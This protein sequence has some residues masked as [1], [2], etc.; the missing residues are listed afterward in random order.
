MS[1]RLVLSAAAA[2]FVLLSG[3]SREAPRVPE[4]HFVGIPSHRNLIV[5][6]HGVLGD[7]DNTWD[8][9]VTHRSWPAMLSEDLPDYDVFVYGYL[10]PLNGTASNIYEISVRM[11]QDFKDRQFFSRY[12]G[13]YFITHSMGGLITKRAMDSLSTAAER[14]NL[15]RVRLILYISVP[16][17]GANSA[18]LAKWISRN[19]QFASMDPS[20]A[21]DFL[22]S[23]EGDWET[24]LHN[25]TPSAPFPRTFSAY[26]KLGVA[27]SVVVPDLYIS[28]ASDSVPV[29]FDYDHI[30]IV[31]PSGKNTDIYRWAKARI[32]EAA[33]YPV[34]QAQADTLPG[35]HII[36]YD[37]FQN[38]AQSG[39]SFGSAEVVSWDSGRADLLVSNMQVP[40]PR[41][42][43]FTQE[44]SGGIYID[45]TQDKGA[46]AG[47]I[48]MAAQTLSEVKEAPTD[49]YLT[50][51]YAPEL[52]GIYCVRARDGH[53]FA[54]IRVT[55]L[56]ADRIAFDWVYQPGNSRKF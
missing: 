28:Y 46:N 30:F 47:I 29:A 26:E 4:P 42:L 2:W 39:F 11:L 7:M 25:R 15:Q 48:K 51:W 17:S 55:D 35:G 20:A 50:H 23:T 43:F 19:P 5:F 52:N 31:K 9:P 8:N 3:C 34:T 44:D 12:D 56:Q 16:S 22:Q 49:G 33:A 36:L 14:P 40:Q 27:G 10:S 32:L 13:I 21:K 41:A 54:K 53:H 18:A 24:L 6:V 38:Y 45:A 37:A 1:V